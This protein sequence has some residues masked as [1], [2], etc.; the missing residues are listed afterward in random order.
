[1][2]VL[3]EST[4]FCI[5]QTPTTA[6]L[7]H[8]SSF[9]VCP[10]TLNSPLPPSPHES[11]PLF[12]PPPP[13]VPPSHDLSLFLSLRHGQGRI[14]RQSQAVQTQ[15]YD[16]KNPPALREEFPLRAHTLMHTYLHAKHTQP[17]M[18]LCTHMHVRH[19]HTQASNI[20]QVANI[21]F[22]IYNAFIQPWKYYLLYHNECSRQ[23]VSSIISDN[24]IW[25][26]NH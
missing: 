8:P 21:I 20:T 2:T 14:S 3:K 19:T 9:S 26:F 22:S 1:M 18:L 13:A 16:R 6:P 10:L 7:F 23:N 24:R 5:L 4:L 12:L 17:D 25:C 11:V 15:L